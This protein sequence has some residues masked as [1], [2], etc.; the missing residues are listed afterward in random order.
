M[1]EQEGEEEEEEHWQLWPELQAVVPF[2]VSIIC[3]CLGSL[4]SGTQVLQLTQSVSGP[5]GAGSCRI[6]KISFTC[7]TP[8]SQLL[9]RQPERKEELI[10]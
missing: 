4:L 8:R 10:L 3:A 6:L 2:C 1:D 5:R 9:V 7:T